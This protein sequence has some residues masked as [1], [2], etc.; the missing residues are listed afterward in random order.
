MKHAVFADTSGW[1][2]VVATREPHHERAVRAY[3][4]LV[5]QGARIVTTNLVLAEMHAL[6]LRERGVAE[7]L[8]LIDRVHSDPSYEVRFVDRDLESEALDRWIRRY[9]DKL[10]SLTDACSF[11]VMRQEGIRK[12]FALDRHFKAAGYE[13]LL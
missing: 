1:L 4:L 5:K 11:E 3:A 10:F 12:A 7:A 6:V 8:D 2:G 13:L 9:S